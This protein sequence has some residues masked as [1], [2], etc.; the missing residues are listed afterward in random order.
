MGT[1]L[2]IHQNKVISAYHFSSYS[3]ANTKSYTSLLAAGVFSRR[4]DIVKYLLDRGYQPEAGQCELHLACY[5]ESL[6]ILR[7]LLHHVPKPAGMWQ[8]ISPPPPALFK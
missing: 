7:L 2:N 8:R 5:Q 4:V 3:A 6:D 1:K